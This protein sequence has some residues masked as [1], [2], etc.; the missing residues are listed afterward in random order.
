MVTHFG[1]LNYICI[2]VHS[3]HHKLI[4]KHV[5]NSQKE[6]CYPRPLFLSQEQKSDKWG[7]LFSHL[8]CCLS[9]KVHS[10]CS[11]YQYFIVIVE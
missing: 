9:V 7:I 1:S 6:I 3:H 11:M 2:V 5:H 4:L 8:L 10:S